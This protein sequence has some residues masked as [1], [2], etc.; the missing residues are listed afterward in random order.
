[1]T[2]Y[3]DL[4]ADTV[5]SSFPHKPF[6]IAHRLADHPLFTLPRLVDLA[7]SL[8]RDQIE[9]SSGDLQPD[10]DPDSIPTIEMPV[11]ETI[12]RIEDCHAWMVIKTVEQDAEYRAFLQTC[13]AEITAKTGGDPATFSDIRGFIF[14]SSANSVT[15]FHV[16]AEHNCFVQIHGD[17][18]MHIFDNYDRSLVSEEA[19]E[20]SP[21][22]HRNQHYEPGFEK[23][24]TVYDMAE[25]DGV[26]LPY[27]W[28]HWVRTG[29]RYSVS[30]AITWKTPEV[31]RQN[32][33]RFMNAFLRKLGMPQAAPGMAPRLDGAKV[34][35][36]DAAHA[37]IQPLR[38]SERMRRLLRQILFGRK[39]NYYYEA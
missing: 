27:M 8:D 7:R 18:A 39:A 11:D 24:A 32:K 37:L 6:S 35:A 14:I 22:K 38:R 1:M 26:F 36:H 21:S 9:Y 28:P 10:Q 16:D 19:M 3:L 5:G 29:E 34:L 25:G 31:L 17:K 12:R 20:I 15:P 4:N 13:L 30:M 2:G 33:V 23:R